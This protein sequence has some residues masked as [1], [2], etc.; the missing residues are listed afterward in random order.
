MIPPSRICPVFG[1]PTPLLFGHRGAVAEAPESTRAAFAHAI[2]SGCDVLEL[3]VQLTADEE[4]VVWHGPDLDNVCITDVPSDV[5]ERDRMAKRFIYQF[6]WEELEGRTRVARPGARLQDDDGS[7]PD[8]GRIM[9]L[10]DFLHAMREMD[11]P[12]RRIPLNIEPKRDRKRTGEPL[13]L[14]TD[15]L[16]RFTDTLDREGDGRTIVVAS[17]SRKL[18][19]RFRAISGGRYPTGVS[20]VEQ[21]LY[22][23]VGP[24]LGVD[25][26]A[27]ETTYAAFT[28]PVM[29]W[30][31]GCVIPRV[32][33]RG[34]S[35]HVFLTPFPPFAPA[36]GDHMTDDEVDACIR[37]V[38]ATGVDG[39]MTDHPARVS[40]SM[41]RILARESSE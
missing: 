12:G 32:Q 7:R 14:S 35:V 1:L 38:L 11:P 26:R 3:D 8:D 37:R 36:L 28:L 34:G 17:P 10:E 20:M 2:A 40:A 4:I 22:P 18:M 30:L 5:A 33:R 16:G 31:Y 21:L 23:F 9:R 6:R 24:L 41:K 15:V 13:F 39:V 25:G 19:A 27:F 29:R